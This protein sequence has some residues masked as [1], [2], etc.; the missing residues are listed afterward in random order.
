MKAHH[1]LRGKQ[2]KA[3]ISSVQQPSFQVLLTPISGIHR[4]LGQKQDLAFQMYC[5]YQDLGAKR[6]RT[7]CPDPKTQCLSVGYTQHFFCL[8]SHASSLSLV[9]LPCWLPD[10][11]DH[12]RAG[13]RCVLE[14]LR[15]IRTL[16]S[17]SQQ[18]ANY[19]K[20]ENLLVQSVDSDKI[21]VQSQELSKH[22]LLPRCQA[23]LQ[24]YMLLT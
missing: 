17:S 5:C 7:E 19:S 18:R 22:I 14:W 6:E 9:W 24:A 2:M 8:L 4:F 16:G 15:I 11:G 21:W 20:V 3:L 10:D 23:L 13:C 12:N 1:I